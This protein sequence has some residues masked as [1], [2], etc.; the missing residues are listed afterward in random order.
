MEGRNRQLALCHH[1][2]HRLSEKRLR[3]LAVLDNFFIRHPDGTTAAERFFETK[4]GDLFEWLLDRLPVPP[5]R[6]TAPTSVE[7]T[8]REVTTRGKRSQPSP[9]SP[10]APPRP[11]TI[12]RNSLPRSLYTNRQRASGRIRDQG[13]SVRLE[14]TPD[15]VHFYCSGWRGLRDWNTSSEHATRSRDTLRS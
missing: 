15:C 3:S 8:P 1:S 14:R 12:S 6:M 11:M 13:P 4:P 9:R 5:D 7:R 10:S 2:L